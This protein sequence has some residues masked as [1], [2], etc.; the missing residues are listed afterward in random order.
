MSLTPYFL[1]VPTYTHTIYFCDT[2]GS[3]T[4]INLIKSQDRNQL[5]IRCHI[6]CAN[7]RNRTHSVGVGIPLATSASLAY[8]LLPWWESNP[9]YYLIKSQDRN[10]LRIQGNLF[11]EPTGYDPVPRVF[12]TR[13]MTTSATAPFGCLT[14]LETASPSSQEGILAF[15]RQTPF[16]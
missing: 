8:F 15:G 14:D 1:P 6:F 13:A 7:G 3:R 5:R 9:H 16:Y 2:G 4:H 10:Q 11:V 12:Q